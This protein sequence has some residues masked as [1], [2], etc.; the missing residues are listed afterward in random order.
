ME[1]IKGRITG[2]TLDGVLTVT[3]VYGNI[4]RFV[5]RKYDVVQIGLPDGRRISPEQRAKAHALIAE[6]ADWQGDMPEFVKRLMKIDFMV[7]RLQSLER[8]IFSLSDCDM[9][10]AR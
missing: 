9:T 3:A 6:I 1:I 10:T 8:E 5:L 7:N 2:I 4:D